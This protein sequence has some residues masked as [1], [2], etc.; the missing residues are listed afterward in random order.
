MAFIPPPSSRR[1]WLSAAFILAI[2]SALAPSLSAAD[3]NPEARAKWMKGYQ[4]M[5]AAEKTRRAGNH[6]LALE[7]YQEARAIFKL[8]LDEY[9]GWNNSL[10]S[11][12]INY[13]NE[14]ISR[15]NEVVAASKETLSKEAL[16]TLTKKQSEEIREQERD[17]AAVQRQ[18]KLASESLE[19]A[20]REAAR[21]ASARESVERLMEDRQQLASVNKTLRSKVN[22]LSS[23]LSELE[24]NAGLKQAAEQLES[25][26]HLVESE[27]QK[28]TEAV[29]AYEAQ[30]GRL[31]RQ[32]QEATVAREQLKLRNQ[33]LEN[34]LEQVKKAAEV[35][36][37]DNAALR[38]QTTQLK[39]SLQQARDVAEL[40]EDKVDNQ[41]TAVKQL[42]DE[43][44]QL[45]DYRNKFIAASSELQD[46]RRTATA[47]RTAI[48]DL[49]QQIQA[50]TAELEKAQQ[51]QTAVQKD[52]TEE[53]A[54]AV[55]RLEKQVVS[56]QNQLTLARELSEQRLRDLLEA[57][58][59]AENV[60]ELGT[61]LRQREK[62]V[63]DLQTRLEDIAVRLSERER[64]L[65]SQ[66]TVTAA[67]QREAARAQDLLAQVNQENATLRQ[68][69]GELK[70]GSQRATQAET[71]NED[72]VRRQEK[73]I[74]DLT[75]KNDVLSRKDAAQLAI[76]RRQ[77]E[78]IRTL[79]KKLASLQEAKTPVAAA[80]TENAADTAATQ[81]QLRDALTDRE[82]AYQKIKDLT[83]QLRAAELK[84]AETSPS[85]TDTPAARDELKS[86]LQET[87]NRLQQEKERVREL[88]LALTR[89]A[90][91]LPLRQTPDTPPEQP[92]TAD[93]Q[94]TRQQQTAVLIQG[95]LEKG[96]A[97]EKA[98]NREAAIWNYEKALEHDPDNALA[99]QRLGAIAAESQNHE[100]AERYLR[101]AFYQDPDDLNTLTQLGFTLVR[102]EKP[103][104]AISMLSRAVALNKDKPE[105]HRSLGIACS[106]LG[107][108][109]AAEMQFRRALALD[110]ND[111]DAAFNL[112]VLLAAK[113]PPDMTE[114]TRLYRKAR[115]LGVPADPQLD[116]YFGYT[117]DE[118]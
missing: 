67:K 81:K 82:Y 29:A 115:D 108:T 70:T 98:D 39:Q 45:R 3:K 2:L 62:Q 38:K 12:R 42:R 46:A 97:A 54:T 118:N 14:L 78:E 32:L 80:A 40:A 41:A 50:L 63:A 87:Q 89:P 107:W 59:Q 75:Q 1:V 100:K 79:Q 49:Q 24:D 113:E 114:A 9:P 90:A 22:E 94:K 68:R 17:I 13:C 35:W 85:N 117:Q 43:N 86:Q 91:Q 30:S 66:K 55:E 65:Q 58:Q 60:D 109:D 106:S 88:E 36:S 27:R 76:L 71:K 73:Q 23:K 102:R 95:L 51:T 47:S 53:R 112:A 111:S 44:R 96:V 77:E 83:Q 116:S 93:L 26:L 64:L 4:K 6:V 37:D 101:L 103:D 16:V 84:L 5:E 92:D 69:I 56:L 21:N 7:Q 18:L 8:V 104:L 20:R 72:I 11:Y 74:Q 33:R 10:L 57:R 110:E 28:L 34:D 31:E 25:K 105:V 19:R 99:L 61:L 15:L 48:A 52:V